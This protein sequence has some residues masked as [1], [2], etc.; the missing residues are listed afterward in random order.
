MPEGETKTSGFTC[1]VQ[2][3]RSLREEQWSP[4]SA[5]ESGEGEERR[6]G[7]VCRDQVGGVALLLV[8]TSCS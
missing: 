7:R 5:S 1:V 2:S 8:I 4:C 3:R 6:H